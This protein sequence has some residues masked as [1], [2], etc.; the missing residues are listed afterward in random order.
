VE[1]YCV[2]FA[3]NTLCDFARAIQ[4]SLHG[5][6]FHCIEDLVSISGSFVVLLREGLVAVKTY[7]SSLP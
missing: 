7:I 5:V 1:E 3:T 6:D 2:V 4:S